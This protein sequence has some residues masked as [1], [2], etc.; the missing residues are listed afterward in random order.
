MKLTAASLTD[1]GRVREKNEDAFCHFEPSDAEALRKKGTIFIVADGIGG[2]QGGDVASKLAV[3]K[4]QETYF[5][6]EEKDPT[7]ALRVAFEEANRIIID[8]A[9]RDA[10]LFGMGTTCTA[11]AVVTGEAYFAHIGDSR[12]YVCRNGDIRQITRDH[13]LVSD[14][15]KAGL[16]SNEE[17]RYHPQRNVITKSLGSQEQANP[18]TPDSPFPLKAGDVFLLCSDG[19]TTFVSDDAIKGI[20]DRMEPVEACKTLID[21]ANEM[22]GRDNITVQVIKVLA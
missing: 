8:R 1:I 10:S 16:L 13:S 4:V 18:D 9:L 12:A 2:H 17:A 21:L 20:L 3:D 22:G 11:M 6:C 5:A 14:L 7:E 15:V 19:L